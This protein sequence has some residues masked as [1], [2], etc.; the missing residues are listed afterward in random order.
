MSSCKSYECTSKC[1]YE[2]EGEGDNTGGGGIPGGY[3]GPTGPTGQRGIMGPIGPIGPIGPAGPTGAHGTAAAGGSTFNVQFKDDDTQGSLAGNNALRFVPSG[4]S[5]TLNNGYNFTTTGNALFLGNGYL[6]A[7]VT[8]NENNTF[9]FTSHDAQTNHTSDSNV[10]F[11]ANGIYFTMNGDPASGTPGASGPSFRVESHDSFATGQPQYPE[12]IVLQTRDGDIHLKSRKHSTFAGKGSIK[13]NTNDGDIDLISSGGLN[14]TDSGS[15]NI[16]TKNNKINITSSRSGTKTEPH[17]LIGV[18]GSSSAGSLN[19]PLISIKASHPPGASALTAGGIDIDTEGG[20]INIVSSIPNNPSSNVWSGE[21]KMRADN[22]IVSIEGPTGTLNDNSAT[23]IPRSGLVQ[24]KSKQLLVMGVTEG[25]AGIINIK[26]FTTAPTIQLGQMGITIRGS[27]GPG[28]K[29]LINIGEG[30]YYG[31]LNIKN[32]SNVPQP[33]VKLE[34]YEVAGTTG[35]GRIT[36]G[37]GGA[38]P[39]TTITL[40]GATGYIKAEAIETTN[41][42]ATNVTATNTL[43]GR[44][45]V[46]EGSSGKL[47]VKN[48]G[49]TSIFEVDGSS[50]GYTTTIGNSAGSHI[51]MGVTGGRVTMAMGGSSLPMIKMETATTQGSGSVDISV[52]FKPWHASTGTIGGGN[53]SGLPPGSLGVST[54]NGNLMYVQQNGATGAAEM[55]AIAKNHTTQIASGS[56]DILCGGAQAQSRS[57]YAGKAF[58]L[59]GEVKQNNGASFAN[60]CAMGPLTFPPIGLGDGTPA[61]INK[62]YLKISSQFFT[63]PSNQYGGLYLWA[64]YILYRKGNG[65]VS[66]PLPEPKEPGN[67]SGTVVPGANGNCPTLSTGDRWYTLQSEPISNPTQSGSGFAFV[68][69]YKGVRLQRTDPGRPFTFIQ[70]CTAPNELTALGNPTTRLLDNWYLILQVRDNYSTGTRSWVVPQGANIYFTS[71]GGIT[72]TTAYGGP[73]NM[74]I[75]VISADSNAL[76]TN[77]SVP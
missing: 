16:G 6:P 23:G 9:S 49:G 70:Y 62:Q 66:N 67:S 2:S 29:S 50:T 47:T 42:T 60:I 4:K 40:E 57:S 37:V 3:T 33:V 15:I 36:L 30:K 20:L 65:S 24:T 63:T 56:F 48:S 61:S 28:T 43:K 77:S 64:R 32:N 53:S 38:N 46:A 34:S 69:N 55:V 18:T 17:I 21:V 7:G 13:L 71:L 68:K 5:I 11:D 19:K 75:E 35:A 14:N 74:S 72:S 1:C 73:V 51:L 44:N 31:E 58:I 54:T 52:P 25:D 59:I 26:D 27:T 22:G 45:I 39:T 10:A 76:Q 41:F 12:R 8:G